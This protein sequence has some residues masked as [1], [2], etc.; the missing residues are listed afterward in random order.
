MAVVGIFLLAC[1]DKENGSATSPESLVGYWYTDDTSIEEV[2]SFGEDGSFSYYGLNMWDMTLVTS[3]GTYAYDP[4]TSTLALQ[5]EGGFVPE[6]WAVSFMNQIMTIINSDGDAYRYQLISSKE[7][8][9][10]VA[11]YL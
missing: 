1:D 2:M 7:F 3:Y 5:W 6:I 8:R 10:L 4:E 11:D 9:D